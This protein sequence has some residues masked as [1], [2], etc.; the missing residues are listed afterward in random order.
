MTDFKDVKSLLSENGSD[1]FQL[2]LKL[3]KSHKDSSD[4]EYYD[5][6]MDLFLRECPS[7]RKDAYKISQYYEDS[8]RLLMKYADLAAYKSIYGSPEEI[9][10]GRI[11]SIEK[12]GRQN[13]YYFN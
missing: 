1:N 4:T 6:M 9:L 12:K 10:E 2:I 3:V 5:G 7:H 11:Q 8:D 13:Q